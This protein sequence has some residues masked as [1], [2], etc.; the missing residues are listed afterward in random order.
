MAL[1]F[2]ALLPLLVA[3]L[4]PILV[5]FA[6]SKRLALDSG[7]SYAKRVDQLW[8]RVDELDGLLS[9]WQEWGNRVEQDFA[10]L[11]QV[12]IQAGIQ[13]PARTAGPMPRR[14]SK[15]KR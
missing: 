9:E 5:F 12:V 6:S 2:N 14:R 4:G 15:D 7:E 11:T 10:A 13:P 3:A 8:E 1:D